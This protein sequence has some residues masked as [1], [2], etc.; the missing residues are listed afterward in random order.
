MQKRRRTALLLMLGLAITSCGGTDAPETSAA[1]NDAQ[2]S[3]EELVAQARDLAERY[4][5]LR[6]R[7]NSVMDFLDRA[8]LADAKAS[9]RRILAAEEQVLQA[10]R[11]FGVEDRFRQFV[12]ENCPELAPPPAPSS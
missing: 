6:R 3:R 4:C 9:Q 8:N 2:L 10:A 5:S 1:P 11:D 12:E 7:G